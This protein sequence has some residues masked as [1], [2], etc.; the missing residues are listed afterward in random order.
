ME[1]EMEFRHLNKGFETIEKPLDEAKLEA[2]KK[3]KTGIPLI[4]ACMR[5][6]VETGYLNF[7]MRAMLVSFL[8]HHLFQEWKV[9]SA[10]LARQF[11]DFE[12]GIHFPQLQITSTSKAP[13]TISPSIFT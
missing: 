9:G 2:W 3:G 8:T 4:D 13:L 11:L 5:C 6:L 10:H 7:R 12:P 1:P